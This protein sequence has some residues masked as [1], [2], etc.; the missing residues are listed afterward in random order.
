M[1]VG[2]SNAASITKTGSSKELGV[3]I[4]MTALLLIPLMAFT[5]F[6]VDTGAWYARAA[7][8]QR[9]A[10]AAAL[11]GAARMPD[12]VAAKTEAIA[13]AKKNGFV[14]GDNITMQVVALGEYKIRVEI[15]DTDVARYFSAVFMGNMRINRIA[16]AEFV[17]PVPLGSPE[18]YFG[19]NPVLPPPGGQ[20]GLWGDIHGPKSDNFNGDRYGAGCRSAMGCTPANNAEYRPFYYYAV[21]VPA[22]AG[23][24]NVQVY[25]AG[26]YK[27]ASQ[28]TDTGDWRYLSTGFM[29]TD[30]TFLYDNLNTLLDYSDATPMPGCSFS[31]DENAQRATYESKW[32]SLCTFTPTKAGRYWI[33]V[34]TSGDG[35]AGNRYSLQAT[36]TGNKVRI[37]GF[38]N[39]AMFNNNIAVNPNFY[40]AE[41]ASI[42]S[43][44]TFIVNLF[45][46]GEIG[47]PNAKMKILDPSGSTANQCKVSVFT[48]P[49]NQGSL[50]T[51]TNLS[52][53]SITTTNSS[54]QGLFNGKLL[55]IE[56]KLPTTYACG[57]C[58]WKVNY[59]MGGASG[60]PNDVT[61]WSAAIKGDPVH[62]INE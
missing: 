41:V 12:F 27:K 6:A 37:S 18:N 50:E 59:D 49:A 32:V 19:N 2:H 5:G 15:G 31:I 8:M 24:V 11:A 30:W 43:G 57:F 23:T 1:R 40:L 44:K 9:A 56:I 54:S 4:I 62:L 48:D 61:T 25:D 60:T 52:P 28:T 21:D 42:H 58:W 7:H 36:S 51:T 47:V 45:D 53:C 22:G 16:I 13:T 17:L 33:K 3:T 14:A 38:Q 55:K 34:Q 26:M 35:A 39:M 10:D 46:P 20:P 29:H